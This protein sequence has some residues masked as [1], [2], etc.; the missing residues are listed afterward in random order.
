MTYEGTL[1]RLRAREPEDA[2]A[3]VGWLSDDETMRYWDRIYP[4]PSVETYAAQIAALPPP[5]YDAG[6][7][8]AVED[9]AS[10][11]LIG[12]AG[13]PRPVPIHRHAELSV[14]IGEAAYRGRGYGTDLVRTVCRFG[15]AR[16]GLVRIGLEY[17]TGNEAGRRAYERVG[18]VEEGV[19]RHACWKDGTWQDT[20]CMAVF[21]ETL[22]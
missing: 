10:G 4:P 9:R 1:V 6:V 18:F 2:A 21:P 5:S 16:M 22:R 7:R 17:L 8:F 11:T 14:L 12:I 15:F 19:R 13:L 3:I 20:V